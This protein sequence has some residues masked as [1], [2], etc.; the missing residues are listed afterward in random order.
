MRLQSILS[1]IRQRGWKHSYY[2]N[3]G[4]G[5]INFEARGLSYHIWEFDEGQPG[6]ESNVR[7][8]GRSEDFYGDYE[9]QILEILQG[10]H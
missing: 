9:A 4:L 7:T 10:W 8:T 3:D 1:Y 2:E 6:A 5:S